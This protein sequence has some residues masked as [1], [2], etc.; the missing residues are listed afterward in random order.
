MDLGVRSFNMGRT[1]GVTGIGQGICMCT[2]GSGGANII[3]RGVAS[4]WD[5]VGVLKSGRPCKHVE[6]NSGDTCGNR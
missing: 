3:E 1:C 6:D 4:V 5:K 2:C